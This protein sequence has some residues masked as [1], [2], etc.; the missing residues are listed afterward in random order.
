MLALVLLASWHSCPRTAHVQ[1]A[2]IISSL[3]TTEKDRSDGPL[4]ASQS[5]SGGGCL[6]CVLLLRLALLTPGAQN[7]LGEGSG[8]VTSTDHCVVSLWVSHHLAG[9]LTA[10]S[11]GNPCQDPPAELCRLPEHA[12]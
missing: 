12:D 5:H 2:G 8:L 6:E 10:T 3:L 9:G 11:W 7:L 4:A 1:W